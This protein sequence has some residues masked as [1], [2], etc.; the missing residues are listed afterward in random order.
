MKK[1]QK[2]E[3]KQ[4]KDKMEKAIKEKDR[5]WPVDEQEED[6]HSYG[7]IPVRDLKKNLGCG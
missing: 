7:G 4:G 2:R 5:T 3:K 1:A 6:R